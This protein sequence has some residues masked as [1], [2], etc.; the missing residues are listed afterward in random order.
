MC[1]CWKPCKNDQK[2]K[3]ILSFLKSSISLFFGNLTIAFSSLLLGILTA[4]FLEP[5]GKGELY[6][7]LQIM[8]V[9]AIFL[10]VGIS[11]AYQYFLSKKIITE[12]KIVSHI[13]IQI[14][15]IALILVSFFLTYDFIFKITFLNNISNL[16]VS[17][18]LFGIIL[19]IINLFAT[20]IVLTKKD[21]IPFHSFL[22]VIGS[23]LNLAFLG[24]FALSD[25]L[26]FN[27]AILS[28]FVGLLV[29]IIPKVY[30]VI[31]NVKIIFL[32]DWFA[33][34]RELFKYSIPSFLTNLAVLLVFKLDTFII[35]EIK[36]LEA[37]GIY[38][39]AV[40]FAE[41]TLMLPNS[42]GTVLFTK[43]PSS[44]EVEK[45]ELL[46]KVNKILIFLAAGIALLLILTSPYVIKIL[47]GKAY[48]DS[49][50]PLQILAPGLVFMSAN[51]VF[52]NYYTGSGN[53]RITAIIYSIGIIINVIL[54]YYFISLWGINGAALA[55][56]LTYFLI[57]AI[58]YFLIK[59]RLKIN[60]QELFIINI[61]DFKEFYLQ[62]LAFVHVK[63]S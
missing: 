41:I 59:K 19:N 40:A 10:S 21:G 17:I 14:C 58:F 61:H 37:L 42:V 44:N 8:S 23:V 39:M 7:A 18:S 1:G 22:S 26:D 30:M 54:N 46:K 20:S 34:T 48:V 25:I 4:R 57:A 50:L 43:I 28:Y 56:T 15:I 27:T 11:P 33:I 52:T 60:F 47:L 3:L 51:Y 49:I 2:N 63:K 5:S 24:I 45:L 29:Q 13:I 53:P 38:S 31:L 36:G 32:F 9:G 6:L 12:N 62:M 35:S 55:S 16:F